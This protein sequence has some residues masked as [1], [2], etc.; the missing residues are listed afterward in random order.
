MKCF[1]II[2]EYLFIYSVAYVGKILSGWKLEKKLKMLME[3]HPLKDF[4]YM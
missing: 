4:L 2:Q 1:I 3:Y